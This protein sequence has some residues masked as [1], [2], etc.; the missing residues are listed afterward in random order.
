MTI[1]FL[2]Q[3][4]QPGGAQRC[5]LDLLPAI[6]D[7]GWRAV[8][9]APAGG[10]LLD[11]ARALRA[12]AVA[13]RF[14]PFRSG[15]KSA[16]DAMRFA[17][18]FPPLLRTIQKLTAGADLV[19]VNGPR[20]VPVASYLR[21]AA[22]IV[23]HC[24]SRFP[25][26]LALV[27]RRLRAARA[28]VIANCRHVADPLAPWVPGDRM[29][30]IY[31]GVEDMAAP[32]APS[33]RVGV[34]GRISPE[35]GQHLFIEAARLL[36]GRAKF[37]IRG[38]ALFGD[39]GYERRV[40]AAAEESGVEVE[41]WSDDVRSMLASLDVLVVPSVADATTRVIPEAFS[42]GVAVVA[43]AT[44]GIP[45]IVDDGVT[46]LLAA[47]ASPEALASRIAELLDSS[48]LRA[49]LAVNARREYERRFTL[50]RWRGDIVV[51][52][53]RLQQQAKQQARARGGAAGHR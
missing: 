46:G 42:A 22:P 43:F 4:G 40:H 13:V 24:H 1:L 32:R 49:R 26:A 7:R 5:L 36:R 15:R 11:R 35:K 38:A 16:L 17:W 30:V 28:T 19:Y 14:G 25:E 2:D 21:T 34:I 47:S 12:E 20:M 29:H 37:V 8:V 33:G 3:L 6:A 41:P 39:A 51:L 31:N 44:G 18:Q 50:S 9:A 23:F 53:E 52:L 10:P 27:G 48:E 45:E